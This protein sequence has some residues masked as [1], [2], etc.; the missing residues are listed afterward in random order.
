VLGTLA[1]AA[2][3]RGDLDQAQALAAESLRVLRDLGARRELAESL[4]VVAG[5]AIARGQAERAVVLFSAA[6]VLRESAGSLLPPA[7]RAL[8]ERDLAAARGA[9]SDAAFAAARSQGRM[10]GLEQAVE[11]ASASPGIGAPG[12]PA[13]LAESSARPEPVAQPAAEALTPR[14]QEV[15]RLLARGLSNR[16]IAE[17]LVIAEGTARNHVEHILAKLGLRSRW[18]VAEWAG[19]AAD[20]PEGAAPE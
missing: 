9:L 13:T 2:R 11:Y 16:Q 10:M 12:E 18:Q 20:E 14:E 17:A 19:A 15:A 3:G 5:V 1:G 4:E 8:H 7:E 6:E